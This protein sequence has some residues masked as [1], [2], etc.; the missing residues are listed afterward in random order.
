[1]L[2]MSF[3]AA[4]LLA[5]GCSYEEAEEG[6]ERDVSLEDEQEAMALVLALCRPGFC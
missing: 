4:Q 6:R 3:L 2:P 5:N 1:M